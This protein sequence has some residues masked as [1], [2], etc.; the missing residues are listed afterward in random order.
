MDGENQNT[1]NKTIT[2][3][4]MHFNLGTPKMESMLSDPQCLVYFGTSPIHDDSDLVKSPVQVLKSAAC[5]GNAA[6][7]NSY[8][9]CLHD[10]S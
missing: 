5:Q 2:S 6:A 3:Q 1:S 4:T 8:A 10:G 9:V 7:R